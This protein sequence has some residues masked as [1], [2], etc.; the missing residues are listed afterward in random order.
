LQ[1]FWLDCLGWVI[2]VVND[3][4]VKIISLD[5]QKD[6]DTLVTTA[7]LSLRFFH[8]GDVGMLSHEMV[9]KLEKSQIPLKSV[10]WNRH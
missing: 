6:Y 10:Q 1:H 8:G 7:K 4:Y 2:D 3:S 5:L 9:S